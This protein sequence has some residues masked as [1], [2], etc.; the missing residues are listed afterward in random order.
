MIDV[1]NGNCTNVLEDLIKEGKKVD[2]IITSPPY[3]L[4]MKA[5]MKQDVVVKYNEYEDNLDYIDYINWQV[6]ILNK[7]Y[8][9]LTDRGLIYYNHKERHF[10]GEYF[11]PINVIQK[12]NLRPLQT[13]IWNRM[14]GMNFNVGRYVSSYEQIVVAYKNEKNYMRISKNAEKYFDVWNIPP[15]PNYMQVATF[16]VDIPERII[17][18]YENYQNL[19]VSDPF[20]GSGTTG[21][22]CKRL[23]VDFIGIELD[24]MY[25]ENAKQRIENADTSG[26]TTSKKQNNYLW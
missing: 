21:V 3:N 1:R 4:G 16:P 19:T 14:C 9:L 24:A 17:K 25:F 10:K 8:D 5:G 12:S 22:A 6:S 23:G 11:N 2:L 18:G 15:S 13:I 7:C 26:Y 20:M